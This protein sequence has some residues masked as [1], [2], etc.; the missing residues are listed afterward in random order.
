M[1]HQIIELPRLLTHQ[2]MHLA[3]QS[4]DQEICGLIAANS[5]G[6]PVQCYP[7]DNRAQSP[8]T[9]YLLDAQQQIS[10]MQ[11]MRDQHQTLF[12]IYHSH[13]HSPAEPSLTDIEQ[14]TY[15]EALQLVISLSTKGILEMR[16][17]KIAQQSVVEFAMRLVE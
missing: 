5:H 11:H 9:R 15:P 14:A 16:I 2:L 4:P 6:I 10:A 13:P 7:I 8:Q 12:A 17:F 1:T 3:Q